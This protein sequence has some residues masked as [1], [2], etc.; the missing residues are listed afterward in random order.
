MKQMKILGVIAIALT[1]G[2]TACNNGGGKSSSHKHDY[3]ETTVVKAAT[4]EQAGEGV[5]KCKICGEEKKVTI[6][7]LGHDLGEATVVTP[8]TCTEDGLQKATCKRC[9]K[10]VE[11]VIKAPGHT[12]GDWIDVTAATCT[13]AGSHKHVCSVCQAEESEE[14]AA[15]GHTWG[16]WVDVEA[17]TC[18]KA[19]SHKHTCSVCQ[20]EETEAIEALG[21]DLQL[22]DG[23]VEPVAGKAT[24]RLYKCSRCE[25][26]Y[27]G[28]KANEPSAD[29]LPHL[30]IGDDGGARFWG[31][32]IGNSLALSAD[33]TSVN[34]QNGEVVYCSTETGDFFEYVFD[35]T[36]AQAKELETC[37]LYCDAQAADYLNGT[38]FWAYGASN[39]EWTPG[40]YIDGGEGHYEVDETTGEPVMVKDHARVESHDAAEAGAELETEVKMGKRIEDYRYILY[41]DGQPKDFDPSIKAPTHGSNTNMRREEFVMPYTFNLHEGE[42]RISLR[43]AGGY[44]SVFYNFTFRPYEEQAPQPQAHVHTWGDD[45][46]IAAAGDGYVSYKKAA[47]ADKDGTRL[48]FRALDGTFAEGST[49]KDGTREGYMKLSANGNKISYKFNYAGTQTKA[50]IYQFGFMDGWSSNSGKDYTAKQSSQTNGPTGCNFGMKF[51]S[52]EV[53]IDETTKTTP[54]SDLLADATVDAGSGNS[55]A[56]PCLVGEILLKNGDNTFEYQRYASYNLAISDFWIV[57]D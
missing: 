14:V 28:F 45:E 17:A 57:I 36:A 55:K 23:D 37:R 26:T 24:V 13:E 44:R 30:V 47:C 12:W 18:E 48:S 10:E 51:N 5:Q 3:G 29:S 31:R 32:P 20:A 46:T 1:L 25:K 34:Q 21:H 19:G 53:Q 11:S 2:L 50:K 56:G 38:D 40:Y 35:L 4:C 54:F 52:E 42:N 15:T 22:V 6:K 16:E 41:V 9:N 33:G 27:L 39:D 49:N 8:A 43:M 7:A